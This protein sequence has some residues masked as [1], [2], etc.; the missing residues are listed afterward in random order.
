MKKRFKITVEINTD[1]PPAEEWG[2]IEDYIDNEIE[3][4]MEEGLFRALEI[5]KTIQE[6]NQL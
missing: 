5:L 3:E 1:T 6:K 4:A 2:K